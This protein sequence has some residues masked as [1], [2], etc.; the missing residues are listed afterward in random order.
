MIGSIKHRL[1]LCAAI[2]IFAVPDS[3][4]AVQDSNSSNQSGIE[5]II[6]IRHAEKPKAGLGQLSVTGL[7]RSLLLPDFF[8]ENFPKPDYI[9][10]PNPAIMHFE[11]HGDRKYHFYIRP[12]L[13]IA[14]TAITLGMPVDTGIG[15]D[16]PQ[17]LVETLLTPKYHS[18]TIYV[19]WEH[20]QIV[21]I[22]K[23]FIHHFQSDAKVPHWSNNDFNMFFVFTIDWN[24][25]QDQLKFD[26][27]NEGFHD[28]SGKAV[29]PTYLN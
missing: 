16:A 29:H 2:I 12:L 6:I 9:F 15:L 22:A 28:L 18:S 25:K 20:S 10:A 27:K 8:K 7:K 4:G 11:N 19:A 14:P 5:T 13:T 24:K 1:L 26:V 23:M 3:A 17:D 21:E